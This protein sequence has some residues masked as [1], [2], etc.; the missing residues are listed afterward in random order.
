MARLRLKATKLTLWVFSL[1][2]TLLLSLCA[3]GGKQKGTPGVRPPSSQTP[4]SGV[5]ESHWRPWAMS[6]EVGEQTECSRE[7]GKFWC[8]HR[9]LGSPREGLNLGPSAT[10]AYRAGPGFRQSD[11]A[12]GSLDLTT[13]MVRMAMHCVRRL[14]TLLTNTVMVNHKENYLRSGGPD[15]LNSLWKWRVKHLKC[16]LQMLLD[17]GCYVY[18]N[19]KFHLS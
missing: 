18:W 5:C 15:G 9:T 1:E 17:S 13:M 7:L 3:Q 10:G 16:I 19:T 2:A 11:A 6:R 14:L 8:A 12:M 4:P